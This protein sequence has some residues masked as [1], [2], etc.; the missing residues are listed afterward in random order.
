MFYVLDTHPI[1]WF[2]SGSPRL[3][4][5]AQAAMSDPAAELIVPAMVLVALP[6]LSA[7]HR[8]PGEG[9]G[10]QRDLVR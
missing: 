8:I 6:G 7:S 5:V 2:V 1:V 9:A 3:T 10:L 4:P